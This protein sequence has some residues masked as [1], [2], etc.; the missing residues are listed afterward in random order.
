MTPTAARVR[1]VAGTHLSERQVHYWIK[2]G[3]I[4]PAGGRGRGLGLL[5][6]DEEWS[7]VTLAAALVALGGLQPSMAVSAARD[8]GSSIRVHL[9]AGLILVITPEFGKPPA[10][11]SQTC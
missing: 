8:A 6:T 1:S 9:A 2:R 10:S 4:H 3:W 7:V 11:T 5:W